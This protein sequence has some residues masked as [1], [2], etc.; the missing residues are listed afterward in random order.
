MALIL[1]SL[2]KA[3]HQL[4]SGL[5]QAL[6]NPNVELLRDGVIQRFEYTYELSWKMLK[7]YF[8]LNTADPSY[9]EAMTF[10]ELIRTG[11]EQGLLLNGWDIWQDYRKAR[12]TTSHTYDAIKAKEIFAIIPQ[13]LKEARYLLESLQ[14]KSHKP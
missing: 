5:D 7:R 14:N 13:F 2:E 12:S 1:S 10:P 11:S 6:Q 8:E 9:V 3:I 4:E